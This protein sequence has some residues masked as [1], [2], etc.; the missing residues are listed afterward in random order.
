M[1]WRWGEVRSAGPAPRSMAN[2]VEFLWVLLYDDDPH[3]P[4]AVEC[5]VRRPADPACLAPEM[6]VEA[7]GVL[8]VGH[9]IAVDLPHGETLLPVYPATPPPRWRWRG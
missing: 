8:A 9:A 2:F 3:A 7:R 4:E 1:R 6:R 5:S